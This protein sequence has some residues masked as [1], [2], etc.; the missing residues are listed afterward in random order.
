MKTC[1]I[2]CE[3]I[4]DELEKIKKEVQCNE[5]V[6]W[7]PSGLHNT[8]EKLHEKLQET[9]K[10]AKEYD[11]IL[12]AMGYCGNSVAGLEAQHAELII[13]RVDDCISLLLGSVKH[14]KEVC[15]ECGTYF[16]TKGWLAGERNL[17]ADYQYSVKK[18]G[19]KRAKRVMNVML[20]NY[21][22]LGVLDTGAY[23]LEKILPET[24][25]IA[26][27]LGLRHEVLPATELY[28][29]RLLT[30]PWDEKQFL[31]VKPGGT[32]KSQE[33]MSFY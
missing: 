14:R 1:I 22:R 13:P 17:W 32:V 9:I 20:H 5:K 21:E 19:E 26:A 29:R 10:T 18:Y 30:G 2:A 4:R 24:K 16:L 11:R 31:I 23:P 12:F 28:F 15:G 8:P 25:K 27:E 33:L 3:T 6:Y 7:L